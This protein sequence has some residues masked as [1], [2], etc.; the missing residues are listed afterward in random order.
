VRVTDGDVAEQRQNDRQPHGR[1]VSG[2]DE[3]VV[4]EHEHDPTEPDI[5]NCTVTIGS[6][7]SA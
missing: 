6:R 5:G 2:D 4:N 3:V 7:P 1:R